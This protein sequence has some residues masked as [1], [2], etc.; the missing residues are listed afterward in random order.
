MEK[1]WLTVQFAAVLAIVAVACRRP[2]ARMW[3][4]FRTRTWQPAKGVID[5][6]YTGHIG[7]WYSLSVGYSFQARHQTWTGTWE[8]EFASE[9]YAREFGEYLKSVPAALRYN[10]AAPRDS[11]LTPAKKP[12]ARPVRLSG[13]RESF[14][15][16]DVAAAPVLGII[17]VL[18]VLSTIGSEHNRLRQWWRSRASSHWPIAEAAI[19]RGDIETE[20]RGCRLVVHYSYACGSRR[21]SGVYERL[22]KTEAEAG[23]FLENLES[24]PVIVRF[25]PNAAAV[26][27]MD[28]YRDATRSAAILGLG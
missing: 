23:N 2:V 3:R 28:P 4:K 10:P 12:T 6:A 11:V 14:D 21:Y 24:L 17:G 20:P 7:K 18:A 15:F 13:F 26:S 8:E 25:D 16:L 5:Y 1:L 22:F 27:V 19:D 9:S